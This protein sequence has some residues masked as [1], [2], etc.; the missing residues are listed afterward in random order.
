MKKACL[1][2]V[3]L[4][5][6][7]FAL[8]LLP[9]E[10][11]AA[12]GTC[13]ENLTWELKDGVLTISGTGPMA[14]NIKDWQDWNITKVI[15]EEG[16][17]SIGSSAFYKCAKLKEV[18]IPNTVTE[19]G[20]GAFR[21]CTSLESVTIPDSVTS[22]PAAAFKECH[23]LQKVSLGEGITV[24]GEAA[25]ADCW[26]LVGVTLGSRV[27]QIDGSAF[28]NCYDLT[29]ID[30]PRTLTKLDYC[31]FSGSGL[32]KIV[33]PAGLTELPKELFQDCVNLTEVIIPDGVTTIGSRAFKGCIRLET[34]QLPK[35]LTAISDSMF[36]GCKSLRNIVIPEG[37]TTLG[38]AA[39]RECESLQEV[40]LP[41][42]LKTI[43]NNAFIY[44]TSLHTVDLPEGLTQLG[45]AVFSHSGIYGVVI[46]EGVTELKDFVLYMCKD[47]RY[48]YIPA[49]VTSFGEKSVHSGLYGTGIWHVLYGGTEAQ[50]NEIHKGKDNQ[51]PKNK[52][53]FGADGTEITAGTVTT[54]NCTE[55]GAVT[56]ACAQ[57]GETTQI[58]VDALG[59]KWLDATC[60]APKTCEVCGATEGN[61]LTHKYQTEIVPPTCT[62]EGGTKQTCT[63]C[64]E[65]KIV[66]PVAALGHSFEEWIQV[67]PPSQGQPGLEE[68]VCNA[69]GQKESRAIP[70]LEQDLTW[71]VILAVIGV[72]G[73]VTAVVLIKQKKK[74]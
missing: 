11:N 30:L 7:A 51:L 32:Q 24:I 40:L 38:V 28:Q 29:T 9:V 31:V 68:R 14:N 20:Y 67:I 46:P 49:S 58:S 47:L 64:G 59:H 15:I 5:L 45:S 27:T 57:C 72:A 42:S 70:Q 66:D 4:I 18:V 43:G 23:K 53:H 22:L 36:L 56:Y 3:A 17:T 65:E 10:A 55:K 6:M 69:C 74:A 12:G 44:C 21:L 71:L 26:D 62:E 34:I 19:I 2:F 35:N 41:E 39:F 16:V 54:P 61:A 60:A 33:L 50:W 1:M 13:G 48:V 52:V 37:V 73:G 25:F 63:L 8:L